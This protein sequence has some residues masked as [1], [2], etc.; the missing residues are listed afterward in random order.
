MYWI[1]D[2]IDLIRRI[3]NQHSPWTVSIINQQRAINPCGMQLKILLH[4]AFVL[5]LACYSRH[6]FWTSTGSHIPIYLIIS[7][8]TVNDSFDY[9]HTIDERASQR[10]K[11]QPVLP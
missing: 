3:H 5:P 7:Y 9:R 6:R 10:E 4:E 11:G 1:T 8:N 2:P